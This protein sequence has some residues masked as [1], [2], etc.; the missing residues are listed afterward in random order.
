[1][2][3]LKLWVTLPGV[4]NIGSTSYIQNHGLLAVAC[5]RMENGKNFAQHVGSNVYNSNRISKENGFGHVT[6]LNPQNLAMY[7]AEFKPQREI[8][9]TV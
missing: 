8:T 3:F 7:T 4:V 1:M 5:F 9:K 6:V 2:S